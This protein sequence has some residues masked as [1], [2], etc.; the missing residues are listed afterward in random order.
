MKRAADPTA[1]GLEDRGCLL[2]GTQRTCKPCREC[3]PGRREGDLAPGIRPRSRECRSNFPFG[4][5]PDR[6]RQARLNLEVMR[7]N[8]E[9]L[10][11]I[12]SACQRDGQYFGAVQIVKSGEAAAFEFG[13]TESGYYALKRIL[14]ARPFD[15]VPGVPCRFFFSGSYTGAEQGTETVIFGVRVEQGDTAKIFEF[16]GPRALLANL[17]WFQGLPSLE[18]APGLRRLDDHLRPV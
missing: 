3:R 11:E 5:H 2:A 6:V 8:H 1:E 13:V 14:D 17:L 4:D 18:P 15:S 16:Q 7:D 12:L 10:P 9:G